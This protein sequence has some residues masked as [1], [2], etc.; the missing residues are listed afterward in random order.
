M[1]IIR[2]FGIDS[3]CNAKPLK[4][5]VQIGDMILLTVKRVTVPKIWRI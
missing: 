2:I 1:V 5:F 3:Q 4:S